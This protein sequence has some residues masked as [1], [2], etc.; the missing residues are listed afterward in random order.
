MREVDEWLKLFQRE[1]E[2]QSLR[3]L[4]PTLQLPGPLVK[5][6][7]EDREKISPEQAL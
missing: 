4:E 6:A 7:S 1:N 5:P 2:N 3:S